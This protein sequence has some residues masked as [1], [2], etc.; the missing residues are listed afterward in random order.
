MT[1]VFVFLFSVAS[2]IAQDNSIR[3]ARQIDTVFMRSV[4][5]TLTSD[6]L[7]G[8]ETGFDGQRK[9]AYFLAGQFKSFGLEQVSQDTFQYHHLSNRANKYFPLIVKSTKFCF[10]K[11]YYYLNRED[12]KEIDLKEVYFLGH[13]SE[14]FEKRSA[15]VPK[16]SSLM[17]VQYDSNDP[18]TELKKLIPLSPAVVFIMS[19]DFHAVFDSLSR[20]DRRG[21]TLIESLRALP[22]RLVWIQKDIVDVINKRFL[23]QL[24]AHPQTFAPVQVKCSVSFPVISDT[25]R[26]YGQNVP[27]LLRGEDYPDEV[28]VV[29][30]H[31]DHLGIE[32]DTI[33][34]GADD[35][36]SGTTAVVEVARIFAKAYAEGRKPRRSILF[37]P[38]SGEEKGLLGSAYYTSHPL[39]PIKK[40]IADV[41]ID[42]VGRIDPEHDSL[43]VSD[44]VYVIGSEMLSSQLKQINEAANKKLPNLNLDYRFDAPDDPNRFYYRSDHYNFAKQGVPSIF[45]FNGVHEDYHQ[46]TDTPDKIRYDAL[47]KRT[48]LVF[49]TVWELANRPAR[50][51]VDKQQ[52][53]QR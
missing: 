32:N 2:V 28:I 42:M 9:A 50:I 18:I 25:R 36:A 15:R 33:Y 51:V 45:Y 41:N 11:D 24:A 4:L 19:N 35:D 8:R 14:K 27:F 21:L 17:Y 16:R 7:E 37:M 31:Y 46:H 30:G 49:L 38:V 48:Q 40:T 3:Y 6:S 52:E 34:Y 29:N 20:A 53:T 39:F 10:G 44:Y 13:I 47:L 22:F 23:K 12:E 43:G 26:F 5:E 1:F